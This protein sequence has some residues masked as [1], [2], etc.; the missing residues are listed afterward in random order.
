MRAL[1]AATILVGLV[2]PTNAAFVSISFDEDANGDPLSAPNAFLDT[3]GLT[4]EFESLG[5]VFSGPIVDSGGAIL[6]VGSNFGVGARS[7]RN[8]FAINESAGYRNSGLA[9]GPTTLTFS[10]P[11]DS[12]SIWGGDGSPISFQMDAFQGAS[13]V[14]SSSASAFRDYSELSVFG[15]GLFDRVV[16]SETSGD[17]TYV[18]DDLSFNVVDGAIP[19]PASIA[20]WSLLL[21]VACVVGNPRLRSRCG[22]AKR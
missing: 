17:G 2:A 9:T 16:I 4:N 6:A 8:F 22:R 7:G 10:Q 14:G 1:V 21:A 13:R 19:E 15:V 11:V 3:V 5:V 12:V 20:I 18:L